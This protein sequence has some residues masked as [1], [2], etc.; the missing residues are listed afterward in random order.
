MTDKV[1]LIQD[2]FDAFA[3]GDVAYISRGSA[4]TSNGVAI[5][6]LKFH[7]RNLRRAAGRRA[8][9]RQDGRRGRCQILGAQARRRGGRRVVATGTWSAAVKSTGRSF[10]TEWA[11]VFGF[12]DGK[13]ASFRVFE[14]TATAAAAFRG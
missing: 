13:I 6:P 11:M 7:T 8:V 12:R 1:K 3:R 10:A 9:L 14:D 5:R 4:T 2:C